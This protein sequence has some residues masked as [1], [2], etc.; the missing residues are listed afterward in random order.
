VHC[1]LGLGE[2]LPTYEN[3]GRAI[4][5]E[6]VTCKQNKSSQMPKQGKKE[7]LGTLKYIILTTFEMYRL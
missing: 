4:I 2:C 1:I 3:K 5:Y 6:L 7:V